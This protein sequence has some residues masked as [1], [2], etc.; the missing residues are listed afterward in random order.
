MP[1][2]G[3]WWAILSAGR[4]RRFIG[5]LLHSG[6]GRNLFYLYLVQGANYLFPLLTLPYLSRVLRPEGFGVLA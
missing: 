5:L 2:S 6:T 1:T 4:L 3:G